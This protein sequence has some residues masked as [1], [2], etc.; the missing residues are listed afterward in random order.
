MTSPQPTSE[1]GSDF[2]AES[3]QYSEAVTAPSSEPGGHDRGVQIRPSVSRSRLRRGGRRISRRGLP[4]SRTVSPRTCVPDPIPSTGRRRGAHGVRGKIPLRVLV[5]AVAR[6]AARTPPLSRVA[7]PLRR[8]ANRS[9]GSQPSGRSRRSSPRAAPRGIRVPTALVRRCARWIAAK[10]GTTA[11]ID[12][13]DFKARG[14]VSE[15]SKEHAWKACIRVYNAYRGFESHP[16]RHFNPGAGMELTPLYA[17]LPKPPGRGEEDGTV[18]PPCKDRPRTPRPWIK[19]KKRLRSPSDGAASC[20]DDPRSP[21]ETASSRSGRPTET[22]ERRRPPRHERRLAAC[23]VTSVFDGR[24]LRRGWK[25]QPRVSEV[26]SPHLCASV[27]RRVRPRIAHRRVR[28][29]RQFRRPSLGPRRRTARRGGRRTVLF[30][31]ASREARRAQDDIVAIREVAELHQRS[32]NNSAQRIDR[33][34]SPSGRPNPRV[35]PDLG[36]PLVPRGLLASGA[37]NPRNRFG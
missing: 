23:R 26:E 6:A 1:R 37:D 5:P 29:E 19:E 33:A 28:H 20:A 2:G 21:L 4:E 34:A 35:D 11:R 14:E 7:R 24:F 9:R 13:L 30:F 12:V 15:R 18:G 8:T 17:R 27:R 32:R 16:L 22:R 10:T 25:I 36:V 31:F 3:C